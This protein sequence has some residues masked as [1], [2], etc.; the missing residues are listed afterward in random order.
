MLSRLSFALEHRGNTFLAVTPK[1]A[2]A[3]T[4]LPA[5]SLTILRPHL[6]GETPFS[7]TYPLVPLAMTAAAPLAITSDHMAWV[8]P[9]LASGS[10]S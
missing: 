7:L 2:A 8:P 9:P 1:P 6:H 3:K 5:V 10:A 4:S